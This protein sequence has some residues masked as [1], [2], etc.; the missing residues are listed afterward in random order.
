MLNDRDELA[1]KPA[2]KLLPVA[3]K[4]LSDISLEINSSANITATTI[5]KCRGVL[6]LGKQ[7]VIDKKIIQLRENVM[8]K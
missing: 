1:F 3:G 7:L 8:N 5:S 2:A 4:L 6:V